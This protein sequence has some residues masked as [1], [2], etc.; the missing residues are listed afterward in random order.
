MQLFIFFKIVFNVHMIDADV[1]QLTVTRSQ[2]GQGSCTSEVKNN[3]H[4]DLLL[5]LASA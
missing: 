4:D 1:R 3:P 2:D 5:K